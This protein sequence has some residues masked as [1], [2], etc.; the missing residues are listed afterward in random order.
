MHPEFLEPQ[1]LPDY[2]GTDSIWG[3]RFAS[4]R[5]Y[6]E[7]LTNNGTIILKFWLNV[8]K[9]EQ[10]QRFLERLSEPEKVWKFS[11]KDVEERQHWEAYMQA[12]EE[13]LNQTSRPWAPWYAVPADEKPFMRLTVA[14]I[15]VETLQSLGLAYPTVSV[16]KQAE[17]RKMK[18]LLKTEE[19]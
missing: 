19:R 7:H 16:E 8:S 1:R 6:E 14:Q 5:E 2:N 15:L 3:E 18:E 10:R 17:F 13:A 11:S 4:I 9:E 12:Y